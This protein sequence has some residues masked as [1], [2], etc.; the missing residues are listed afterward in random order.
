LQTYYIHGITIELYGSPKVSHNDGDGEGNGNG[1]GDGIGGGGGGT[2]GETGGGTV[3]T[4]AGGA[5]GNEG[6]GDET[7]RASGG[8]TTP[9]IDLLGVGAAGTL[10]ETNDASRG[11]RV[12]EMMSVQKSV[13]APLNIENPLSPY[14]APLAV[15]SVAAGVAYTYVGFRKRLS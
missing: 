1:K 8:V 15:F 9:L 5:E 11:W 10:S 12:Y 2:G 6:T 3:G 13:V 14:A 4:G 7:L